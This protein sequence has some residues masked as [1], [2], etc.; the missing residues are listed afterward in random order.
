MI[1]KTSK[2]NLRIKRHLRL[3]VKG[4]ALRPRLSIF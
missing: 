1:K 2:N 4:T 3:A